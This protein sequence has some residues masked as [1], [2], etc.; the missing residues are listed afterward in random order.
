VW[1]AKRCQS[2][3]NV[4]STFSE[5]FDKRSRKQKQTKVLN[6]R[7][8]PDRAFTTLT[9]IPSLRVPGFW[10]KPAVQAPSPH[11]RPGQACKSPSQQCKA[12][13][14]PK[15]A[16]YRPDPALLKSYQNTENAK[17]L[18]EMKNMLVTRNG[19]ACSVSEVQF[20]NWPLKPASYRY[21]AMKSRPFHWWARIFC[22][23]KRPSFYS[24]WCL[25]SSR[26]LSFRQTSSSTKNFPL[27]LFHPGLPDFSW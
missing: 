6:W 2:D 19:L 26:S 9:K 23:E 22:F 14:L 11:T 25:V 27:V 4:N 8:V 5:F 24:S 1:A 21:E 20:A 13:A 17:A 12:W 7:V 15:P 18:P 10:A 3:T 16:F